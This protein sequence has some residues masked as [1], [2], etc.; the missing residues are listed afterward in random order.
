MPEFLQRSLRGCFLGGDTSR[1]R[2]RAARPPPFVAPAFARWP[3]LGGF[4]PPAFF[5]AVD[6]LI[7]AAM[8]FGARRNRR[9]HPA[10]VTG[11]ALVVAV[12]AGR[13]A[14]AGTALWMDFARWAIS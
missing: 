10:F 1:V 6:I 5:A 4:G 13:L 14:L 7:I 2:H 8:M 3:V 12:Q 11:L 9:L